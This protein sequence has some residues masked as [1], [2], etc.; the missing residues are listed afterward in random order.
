MK[1]II[2]Q[3]FNFNNKLFGI[4]Y[5][6][7]LVFIFIWGILIFSIVNFFFKNIDIKIFLWISFVFPIT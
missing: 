1:F 6:S 4:I 7:N 5:Y 2:P 3:N